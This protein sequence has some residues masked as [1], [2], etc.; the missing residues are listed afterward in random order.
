MEALA[1]DAIPEGPVWQYE[2]K[3]NGYRCLSFRD[4]SSFQLPATANLLH[5]LQ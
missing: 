2:S 1:V 3:W 5:L 4:G